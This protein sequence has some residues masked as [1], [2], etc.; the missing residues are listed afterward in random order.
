MGTQQGFISRSP[1][2]STMVLVESI[3][4]I[5]TAAHAVSMKIPRVIAVVAVVA[6]ALGVILATTGPKMLNAVEMTEISGVG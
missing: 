1:T 2:A 3:V 4:V 6:V 5:M